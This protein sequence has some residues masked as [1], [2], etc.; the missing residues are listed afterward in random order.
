[1]DASMVEVGDDVV[2][3]RKMANVRGTVKH[4]DRSR[5]KGYGFLLDDGRGPLWV[6]P[7]HD[8]WTLTEHT[9]ADR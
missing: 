3:T 5:T 8:S 9:E 6:G 1:M 7:R 2:L 4:I